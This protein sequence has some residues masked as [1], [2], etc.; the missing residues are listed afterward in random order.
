MNYYAHGLC[1]IDVHL[2]YGLGLF[3]VL[4]VFNDWLKVFQKFEG[5]MLR[6]NRRTLRSKANLKASTSLSL[7]YGYYP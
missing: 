7:N 3:I 1:N 4:A 6:K 2:S 5:R